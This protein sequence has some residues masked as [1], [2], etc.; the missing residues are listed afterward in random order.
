MS[1]TYRP[2]V[3][4][5]VY[6]KEEKKIKYLLLK[7]KLHWTGWEFPKGGIKEKENLLQSVRR[8]V[9]E[10]TGQFP[11]LINKFNEKGEYKYP[12]LLP[13]RQNYMGQEYILFAAEIKSKKIKLD[14]KEHSNFKWLSFKEAEKLLTYSNQ[15]KCLRIV[16][17]Y[18]NRI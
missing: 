2:S 17:N 12:T 7:R 16:N 9:L 13:D 6:R 8:E 10:E 4:V 3:F 15:K 11:V 14:K 18:L 1:K 5:V